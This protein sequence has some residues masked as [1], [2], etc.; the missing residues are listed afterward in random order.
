MALKMLVKVT[1]PAPAPVQPIAAGPVLTKY[2]QLACSICFRE[3][4]IGTS[5]VCA[6]CAR[7][8]VQK[9]DVMAFLDK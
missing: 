3:P 4:P 7:G 2:G 5:G 6:T 8:D 1:P 9:P